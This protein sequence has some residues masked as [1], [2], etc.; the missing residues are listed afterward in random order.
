MMIYSELQFGVLCEYTDYLLHL[1]TADKLIINARPDLKAIIPFQF[2]DNATS[3][4][5]LAC[6]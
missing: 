3:R 1:L 4:Y 6:V 2:V 5:R